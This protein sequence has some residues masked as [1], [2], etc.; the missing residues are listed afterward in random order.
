M[1]EKIRR[2]IIVSRDTLIAL[3]EG[4]LKF[5]PDVKIAFGRYV[6]KKPKAL[7]KWIAGKGER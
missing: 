3:S 7:V 2:K 5:N 4:R 6:V 1:N